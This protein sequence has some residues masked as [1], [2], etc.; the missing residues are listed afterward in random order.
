MKAVEVGWI[1]ETA[2]IVYTHPALRHEV[3]QF[4][5]AHA[6]VLPVTPSPRLPL[7]VVVNQG[8][9]PALHPLPRATLVHPGV[10]HLPGSCW[11]D[12][13]SLPGSR[14]VDRVPL[15]GIRWVD[16]VPGVGRVLPGSRWV[17]RVPGVWRV[18]GFS[19]GEGRGC[20]CGDH[21]R[22]LGGFFAARALTGP[23]KTK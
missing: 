11:V 4:S 1:P 20:R 19:G 5:A 23:L 6:G 9:V 18:G 12:R 2:C 7:R 8:G 17:D 14:W 10:D 16:R 21:D 15:P 3:I 22:R 13:V